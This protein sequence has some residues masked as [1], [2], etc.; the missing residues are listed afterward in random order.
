MKKRFQV[1][2]TFTCD[3]QDKEVQELKDAILSGDLQRDF[4]RTT[5]L[6]KLTATFKE[7]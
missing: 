7:V 6:K 1:T 5:K 4:K 2:I 3:D